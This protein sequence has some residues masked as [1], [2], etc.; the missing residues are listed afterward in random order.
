MSFLTLV[1]LSGIVSME[2]QKTEKSGLGIIV[3]TSE[4]IF[5]DGIACAIQMTDDLHL[6]AVADNA[7]KTVSLI[8]TMSPDLVIIDSDM[9]GRGTVQ[10]VKDLKQINRHIAILLLVR[11]ATSSCLA[12]SLNIGVEGYLLRNASSTELLNAVRGIC[13]GDAV[14]N[15]ETI[16]DLA[17]QLRPPMVSGTPPKKNQHLS[18]QESQVLKLASTGM[19]NKLISKELFISERTVQSHFNAIFRKFGVGSRTEAVVHALRND[20]IEFEALP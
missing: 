16:K 4:P 1:R 7:E 9:C 13:R 18:H 19:S 5:A 12:L 17:N 20:H 11:K 10:L 6:V 8:D 15:L 3:A 2:K 14:I